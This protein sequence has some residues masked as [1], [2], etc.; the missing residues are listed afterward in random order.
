MALSM[1]SC[2]HRK[3]QPPKVKQNAIWIAASVFYSKR[4]NCDNCIIK[5]ISVFSSNSAMTLNIGDIATGAV[6]TTGKSAQTINNDVSREAN[7]QIQI[8]FSPFNL[9]EL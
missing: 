4:I 8:I 6:H 7:I 2:I 3:F 1:N 9:Q 5:A